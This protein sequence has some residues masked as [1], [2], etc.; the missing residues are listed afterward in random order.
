[1]EDGGAKV[2]ISKVSD[3]KLESALKLSIELHYALIEERGRRKNP[4]KRLI[5]TLVRI[6]R[7]RSNAIPVSLVS[8]A[9]LEEMIL[10]SE[11]SIEVY[12]CERQ[13]RKNA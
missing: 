3:V 7:G 13:R 4:F 1:M 8:D 12:A 10:G 2:D 5:R 11:R 6:T 9:E